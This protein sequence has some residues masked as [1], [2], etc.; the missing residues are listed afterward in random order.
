MLFLVISFVMRIRGFSTYFATSW[1]VALL[2]SSMFV[3]I[4]LMFKF[5]HYFGPSFSKCGYS[6][7][8]VYIFMNLFV[9]VDR[10]FWLT[11]LLKHVWLIY[12]LLLVLLHL[13][14][15]AVLQHSVDLNSCC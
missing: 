13:N 12:M 8:A 15:H 9:V 1:D 6:L 5:S 2:L 3:F 7:F 4:I 11:K 10:W 14:V